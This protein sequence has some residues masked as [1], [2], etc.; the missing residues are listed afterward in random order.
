MMDVKVN[1]PDINRSDIGF[2][3]N[4]D[5]L[6]YG[7]LR[8]KYVGD[9]AAREI[10]KHRPYE[11]IDHFKESVEKKKC[12]KQAFDNLMWAGAFDSLGARS[13]LTDE[14][15]RE[16]EETALD[17][18]LTGTGGSAKYAELIESR[19]NT[20]EEFEGAEEGSGIVIGGEITAVRH[21][22]IKSGKNKGKKM[23]FVEVSYQDNSWNVTIFKDKYDKYQKLLSNGNVI[24]AKGRKG[25]QG[26][27]LLHSM[28]PVQELAEALKNG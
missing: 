3:I 14:E 17:V 20:E 2:T 26:E 7:L 19:I 21:H 6:L 16:Q 22:T 27:V 10:M 24:M 18:A 25:E 1:P 12:N 28:I 4:D 5:E 9:V 15:K 11:S 23:G 13:D 8:V